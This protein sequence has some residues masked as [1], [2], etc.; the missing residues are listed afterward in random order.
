MASLLAVILPRDFTY[1]CP[2]TLGSPLS[3]GGVLANIFIIL[4][5]FTI[6]WT[7]SEALELRQAEETDGQEDDVESAEAAIEEVDEEGRQEAG[8]EE[9]TVA[10]QALQQPIGNKLKWFFVRLV[11]KV[12]FVA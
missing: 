3:S 11:F 7:G 12:T 10:P 1:L 4:A 8:Q 9:E 6:S 2:G 5:I